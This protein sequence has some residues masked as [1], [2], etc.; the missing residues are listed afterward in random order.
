MIKIK[1]IIQIAILGAVTIGFNACGNSI[2]CNTDKVAIA[3]INI[4][5][6]VVCNDTN[7]IDSYIALQSGDII[8]KEKENTK[9]TIYHNQDNIKVVCI[10]SGS[11]SIDRNID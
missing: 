5:I 6:D 4:A 3:G 10:N 11:A 1:D 7:S 2:D 8:I 9:I